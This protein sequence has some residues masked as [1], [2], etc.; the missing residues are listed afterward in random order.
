MKNILNIFKHDVQRFHKNVIAWIVILGITVV[1]ALYAWFNIAASWDPYENTKDL[2]VAVASADKGYEGELLPVRLNLGDNVLSAL[3]ENEQLD[4]TFTN[5]DKALDGVKSG[6][7]YAAI[8]IPEDFSKNLMSLFSSDVTNPE[9][10]YYSNAKENAIAPKVTDKGASAVQ[11]QVKEVFI[12]TISDTALSAMQT[13]A[14][15]ADAKGTDSI[16]AALIS[17]LEK[18]SSDLA[19]ASGTIQAFAAM[20]DSTQQML[21]TTAAFLKQSGD[22]SDKSL[23][24]LEQT[25]TA[26][27][28]MRGAVSGATDGIN[29]ALAD[30]GSYYE[31]IESAIRDALSALSSDTSAAADTLDTL[32]G[33][34][35]T[36]ID[37][38][39]AL[40]DT[41]LV[42]GEEHP[43]LAPLTGKITGR[44]NESISVQETLRDR[45]SGTAASIRNHGENA[46]GSQEELN[47]LLQQ[48][49]QS[50]ADVKADYEQNVKSSLDGLFG[51]LGDTKS[52]I[53]GLLK[54]LDDCAAGV[55]SLSGPASSDLSQIKKT[56]GTSG[57]LL[58]QVS[59][60]LSATVEQLKKARDSGDFGTLE[61]IIGGDTDSISAF[62][63]A[64]V[65]L[66]T[67]KLYPIENYGSSMA[68]FYST[69]AIWVGGI[70]LVAML[71]VTVSQES[72]R[73]MNKVK[74]HQMY[75]GRYILF[76][77]IGLMQSGLICLGDL[78]YLEIQCRHPFLFLLA[79]WVTSIV[80]VNIIYTLTVSFGDIGKAICVVLLVMQVAGSGGTFP[81]EV[82]PAFF[83][84]VYPLLP[85]T[86]SMAAMRECIGGMYG[87]TY[88]KELGALGVFLILSLILGLVL[89]KPVIRLNEAF[90]EKLESTHLI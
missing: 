9:I 48:N 51:S 11:T 8:V 71:K 64:P 88:I 12:E 17:N 83:R 20:T 86:H 42:L 14:D 90:T 46:A 81:I 58:D 59:S 79:G 57:E 43:E 21:E 34:V 41:F 85:F 60:R 72:L 78:F 82:A 22:H 30:S 5:R 50:L 10:I 39:Q 38:Y 49:A 24:T 53:S 35:G 19:A 77:I 36:M 70:V 65:N 16:V 63:S 69:L 32:A 15:T 40:S 26:F 7:Y 6:K 54:Q 67:E 76:L 29:Q 28:D 80:Y 55:Y 31:Q 45:L 87:M 3:R 25:E 52:S 13:V 75:L 62:L 1:P 2:K 37:A 4:W 18:T 66:A 68:P 44:M 74:D 33:K 84:K 73:G 61:N 56:L 27:S 89:R 23:E 47:Q